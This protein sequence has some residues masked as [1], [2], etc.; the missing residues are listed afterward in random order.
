[1]KKYI[2]PRY[3]YSEKSMKLT[4]FKI[5]TWE[6]FNL[7]IFKVNQIYYKIIKVFTKDLTLNLMLPHVVTYWH[8]HVQVSNPRTYSLLGFTATQAHPCLWLWDST[9]MFQITFSYWSWCSN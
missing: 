3:D 4:C 9:Q 6:G 5:K 1:M 8:D 2:T 7:T